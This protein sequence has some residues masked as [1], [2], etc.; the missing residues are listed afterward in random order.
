LFDCSR[1]VKLMTGLELPSSTE[2]FLLGSFELL[3]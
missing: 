1:V 3:T 2:L